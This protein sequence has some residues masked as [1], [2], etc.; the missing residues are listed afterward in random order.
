MLYSATFGATQICGFWAG[1][2]SPSQTAEGS[3]GGAALGGDNVFAEDLATIGTDDLSV[4][5]YHSGLEYAEAP[6]MSERQRLRHAVDHGADVA[7]GHHAHVLQGLEIYRGR[8]IAYSMGN[9]V[10]LGS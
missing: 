8:L 2:F 1:T 5:Q 9:F 4:V 10:F 7:I 3:K 6:A